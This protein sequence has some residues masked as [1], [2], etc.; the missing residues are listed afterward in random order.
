VWKGG[1]R[2]RG[3]KVLRNEAMDRERGDQGEEEGEH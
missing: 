1:G 2:D 3:R